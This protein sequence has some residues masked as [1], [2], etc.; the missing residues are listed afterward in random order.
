MKHGTSPSFSLCCLQAVESQHEECVAI[1]LE[2]RADPNLEGYRG[3]SALHLAA[4]APNTSVAE[5]L[6][7]HG[8]HLEAKDCVSFESGQHCSLGKALNSSGLF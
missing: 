8:A 5:M 6:V 3:K 4:A 7:E 1:L 2:H